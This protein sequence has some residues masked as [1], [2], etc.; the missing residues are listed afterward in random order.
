[1]Q[2]VKTYKKVPLIGRLQIENELLAVIEKPNMN[3]DYPQDS[4]CN[5][6]HV[7]PYNDSPRFTD[8]E[9]YQMFGLPFVFWVNYK[10]FR[11]YR[12]FDIAMDILVWDGNYI[13]VPNG[14]EPEDY[15]IT[16][17]QE[18]EFAIPVTQ[19]EFDRIFDT[20][21]DKENE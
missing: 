18:D 3:P 11:H 20:Y 9:K 12:E 6:I 19:D 21:Y 4:L 5:G 16:D 2:K 1:M 17:E 10:L 7:V 13:E 15:F 8:D 14:V